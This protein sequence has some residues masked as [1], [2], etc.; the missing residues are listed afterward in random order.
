MPGHGGAA[1]LCRAKNAVSIEARGR[2]R[3]IARIIV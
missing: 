3:P 1:A 2:R